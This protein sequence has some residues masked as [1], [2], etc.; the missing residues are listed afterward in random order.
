MRRFR[1]AIGAVGFLA[2]ALVTTAQAQQPGK[3]FK[4]TTP[5]FENCNDGSLAR[6]MK[7]GVTLGFSPIPP[8]S[9]INAQTKEAEGIDVEIH[10]AVLDWIGIPKHKIEWMP[11][12]SQVPALLSKRTDLVAGNI[13]VN[14]ERVKVL[15]FTG[16]AWW[17]GPVLLVQ[18]GNPD[19]IK[20]YAD[21][22]GKQVGA[23]SGSAAES[24]LRRIGIETVTFKSENEELQSLNQGRIKAALEDDVV[25]LEFQREAPNNKIEPLWSIATPDD[26][27]YG[28][29]YGYARYALRKEDCSLRSAY[30]QALA[31]IRGNGQM[32]AILKKFGL[33]DRNLFWFKLNP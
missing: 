23:I 27:I 26:I 14:P 16:P 19:G 6:A 20:G 7:D 11:W 28:G 21:L 15:S 18:K 13:H 12:E 22:K 30:T 9:W 24:Y 2:L 8:H 29:G 5:A 25:F 3:F 4:E 10:K 32:S 1:L 17:Y 31:E 33:G